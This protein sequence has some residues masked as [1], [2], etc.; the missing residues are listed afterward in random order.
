LR[1]PAQSLG[2]FSSTKT[3]LL[4]LLVTHESNPARFLPLAGTGAASFCPLP[5]PCP[6]PA[7]MPWNPPLP[8]GCCSTAC[9]CR[10]TG[11][12][13][14]RAFA[15]TA[16]FSLGLLLECCDATSARR[17]R[18]ILDMHAC[19]QAEA[20]ASF[21]TPDRASMAASCAENL[22]ERD[23][24]RSARRASVAAGKRRR[25]HRNC[26]RHVLSPGA[27][28]EFCQGVLSRETRGR[29][30]LEA[31]KRPA[32]SIVQLLHGANACGCN[33]DTVCTGFDAPRRKSTMV[34]WDHVKDTFW[35]EGWR[36]EEG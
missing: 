16:A 28:R 10:C 8:L 4:L 36:D 11:E 3:F 14:T 29:E 31:K 27:A 1:Q 21:R 25:E 12:S 35:P 15:Q 22:C 7:T 18:A 19:T 30:A 9:P 6:D 26:E 24:K 17:R 5:C 34:D 23:C 32:Q 2:E 20:P 13:T 33:A